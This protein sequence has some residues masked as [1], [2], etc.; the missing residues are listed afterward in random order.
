MNRTDRL[1][2]MVERLRAKAPR[3]TTARQLA[4][5][6]EVST[7]T[8]ERDVLALQEAGVPIWA[9]TGPGGGYTVDPAM[10]LPPLNFTSAEA[11]AI[12]V[13][14]AVSGPVPFADAARAALRKVVAAMPS[15]DRAR[16]E[17]LVGRIHLLQRRGQLA[18][19]PVLEAV[20]QA[21]LD[22]AVLEIDYVDK[23][24]GRTVRSVEPFGFTGTEENWYLLGWC[25]LRNCG[26]TFRLDR[27]HHAAL[28]GET[29]PARSLREVAGEFA[30]HMQ[31]LLEE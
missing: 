5:H 13:A 18:R 21:I 8:I 28:T 27:I 11:T 17:D 14:L 10:S 23:D 25:R 26:R 2:A 31:P 12:A 16:A 9:S 19:T 15:T 4:T 7:R 1:Y 24:G 20:E 30:D 29:A 22:Q 6:F 3:A